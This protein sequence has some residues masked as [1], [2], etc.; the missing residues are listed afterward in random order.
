MV[1]I[2]SRHAAQRVVMNIS[3]S[4]LDLIEGRASRVVDGTCKFSCIGE[5]KFERGGCIC[6]TAQ[7]LLRIVAVY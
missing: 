5:L 6:D 1:L 4:I 2:R 7:V 3:H